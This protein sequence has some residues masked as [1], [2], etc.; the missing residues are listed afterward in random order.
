MY[1][2]ISDIDTSASTIASPILLITGCNA[3]K[4]YLVLILID[5]SCYWN[6]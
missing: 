4:Y 1:F 5:L 3:I 2:N 6:E